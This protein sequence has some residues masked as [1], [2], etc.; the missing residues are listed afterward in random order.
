MFA[1]RKRIFQPD[2]V[3]SIHP[4]SVFRQMV[5]LMPVNVMLCELQ[6]FRITYINASTR[7]TLRKI[8]HVLPVRVDQLVGTSIDVFHKN[9]IHQRRMLA[10][11]SILPHRAR[12]TIGGEVLD[13]L[14]TAITDTSGKYLFPM[15]TWS[16]VTEQAK[17]E[18]DTARLLQMM[19]NMPTN[20]MMCDA[21]FN[22]IYANRTSIDTLGPLQKHLP[23]KADQV[24]GSNIDIFH[25]VPMHQRRLLSDPRNLPH[26]AKIRLGD[27][28]L[29][30]RVSALMDK[31]GTISAPC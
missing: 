22:I 11:P 30:L 4:D 14:V 6:D 8:E 18:N 25:K 27:E 21:D 29:D 5:E 3:R 31:K 17:A 13:L 10:D 1:Q 20:V 16:L 26:R 2:P 7:E 19:D 12:I 15:L 24:V 28:T 9:P 23:V